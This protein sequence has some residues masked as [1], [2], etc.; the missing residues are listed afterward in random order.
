MPLLVLSHRWLQPG[1]HVQVSASSLN[2][3]T[4][5]EPLPS[6]PAP[7][8]LLVF[9][10]GEKIQVLLS[11]QMSRMHHRA[12]TVCTQGPQTSP[13]LQLDACTLVRTPPR[14]SSRLSTP[15]LPVWESCVGCTNLYRHHILLLD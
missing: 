5:C 12:V 8:L 15:A 6:P 3:L 1:A 2:V 11:Q 4:L 13:V 9:F 7:A 10:F 14:L